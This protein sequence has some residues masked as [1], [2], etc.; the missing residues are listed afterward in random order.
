MKRVIHKL[1]VA[2]LLVHLASQA[3]E[4]PISIGSQVDKSRITIGDVITYTVTITHDQNV[5]IFLPGQAANLGGFEIRDYEEHKPKK[6]DNQIVLQADYQISTFMTGEFDIPPLPVGYQLPGDSTQ[7]VLE[8]EPI[9]IVVES[10]KPSEEGDINDIKPPESIPLSWWYYGRWVALGLGVILMALAAYW[11]YRRKKAGEPILGSKMPPRPPH[12]IALDALDGLAQSD[13]LEQ[14]EIKAYYTELSDIMRH[15]CEG[16]YFIQAMEMTTDDILQDLTRA[17]IEDD[18]RAEF[19]SL[20]IQS[21]MVK[22]A[23][24]KPERPI[25]EDLL[26]QARSL[27]EKTQIVMVADTAEEENV[28][29]VNPQDPTVEETETVENSDQK[30]ETI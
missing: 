29:E 3:Q 21:D 27:V 30:E 26:M 10:V 2:F 20:F 1:I 8:S 24:A 11:I 5:D 22:F 25:S 6:I 18:N 28:D 17:G 19:E 14:G 16:R 7:Q 4:A 15:Y 12:E 9:H 13:L 23:K